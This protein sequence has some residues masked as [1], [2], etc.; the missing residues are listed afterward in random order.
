MIFSAKPNKLTN[1]SLPSS[2]AG[3]LLGVLSMLWYTFARTFTS[4][5]RKLSTKANCVFLRPFGVK[6]LK[7]SHFSSIIIRKKEID[8]SGFA[9]LENEAKLGITK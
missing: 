5:K 3:A 1:T 8:Q 9:E 2:T 4:K 7:N 6:G